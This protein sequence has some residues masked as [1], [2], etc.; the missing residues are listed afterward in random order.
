M[1]KGEERQGKVKRER[2]GREGIWTK[3]RMKG[4][5]EEARGVGEKKREGKE[6]VYRK[7]RDK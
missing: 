6:E 1:R 3:R 5:G 7:R 4:R 2:E